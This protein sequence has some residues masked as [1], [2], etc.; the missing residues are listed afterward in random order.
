MPKLPGVSCS[1][2]VRNIRTS[3]WKV[4]G[5]APVWRTQILFFLSSPVSLTET[6]MYLSLS[7]FFYLYGIGGWGLG[8]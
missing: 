3:N 2:V 7:N 4:L 6:K 5:S 1:S 8:T